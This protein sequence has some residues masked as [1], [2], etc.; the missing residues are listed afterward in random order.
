MQNLVGEIL[1]QTIETFS[2][3]LWFNYGNLNSRNLK[4][5]FWAGEVRSTKIS[6]NF[7][8]NETFR[9]QPHWRQRLQSRHSLWFR[10]SFDKR[11]IQMSFQNS[12]RNFPCDHKVVDSMELCKYDFRRFAGA[13]LS[14]GA[15]T[16]EGSFTKWNKVSKREKKIKFTKALWLF[17][18]SFTSRSFIINKWLYFRQFGS[19]RL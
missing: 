11:S 8:S 15:K 17:W 16:W 13:N 2:T 5:N 3:Q 6:V 14:L 10:N 9:N 19:M 7:S 18:F 1:I 12:W 4:R